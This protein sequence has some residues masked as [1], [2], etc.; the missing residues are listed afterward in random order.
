MIANLIRWAVN[1][2]LIVI[3]LTIALAAAGAYAFSQ[4][5]VEAYPDP[6]PA[7]VEVVAQYP[8]RSAEEVER[9]VTIPLEVGLSGMPGLK[10]V[11]SKSLFGLSFIS[12]QFEYG[13]SY[14]GARQEVINRI[15]STNLPSNV[16]PQISPRSPIGEILRYVVTGPKDDHG[17]NIYSLNDLRT[18]ESWTLERE[19]RRIV[20]IADV[21]SFGGTIKRYEIH[22]DPDRMKRYG[23]TLD[24]LQSAVAASNDNVSGDY[25]VQGESV[26]VVRGLGLIG[27]GRDPMQRILQMNSAEEAVNY[28]RNEE[29][30]R[31]REIRQIVL[32]STNNLPVRVGDIVEGGPLGPDEESSNRGVVV[33]YQTRLGKVGLSRPVKDKDGIEVVDK[34]D[35][36]EWVDEGDA[37]QGLAL[38]RKGAESLPALKL[39]EA[40]I[41]ELNGTPGRLPP[42]VKIETFYDRTDLINLTTETVEENL[43][44]GIVLVTVILLMFLSNVR[45]AII[46]AINLPLALL[47]AFGALYARGQS[48]NLL[49]IGAVDFGIIVDSTVIMVENIYRSLS[50]GKHTELPLKERI[51]LAAH[52][53]ERSLFFS[54]L[55]MVCAMLPLFTMRG[56]EGQLFRPMAETYAFAIGGALLL[57]LTL[58]PVLCLLL[59][60][61]LQ[62]SRDNFLVRFLKRGYLRNL[63][64]CLNHRALV[65]GGFAALLVGT[66]GALP[67]LGREFM[68]PLEEGHLWIRGFYPV[69]IS[70]DQNAEKSLIARQIM[71][72]YPEVEL[73]VSQM[74][75]PDSGVDP[76]SFYSCETLVP[77]KPFENWPATVK[78]TGWKSW[79]RD[80]R[81]RTKAELIDEMS[82]ELNEILPG[83][84]WTFTQTIRDTVLEVL[85]GVQGENSVKIIGADLDELEAIGQKVVN[86]IRDVP[87]IQ[88]VGLYRIK[89]QSNLELPIDRE[90]CALWNIKPA[91]VHAVIQSAIGGQA[92][93]QMIEG[94]KSFDITIRWPKHLREDETAILDIPVDVISHQ[95]TG[96]AKQGVGSTPVSGASESVA[97]T[98]FANPLPTLTGSKRSSVPSEIVTTPRERIRD[99]VTPQALDPDEPLDPQG[100]FIRPGASMIVRDQG[101]RVMSVKFGVRGRD[102]AGAVI[103]A[104]KKVAAVIPKGYRTVWSGEFQQM[105]DG[106]RRLMFIIPLALALIF[107]LLYLAFHSF[108]DAIVVLFNV[109]A[110]SLGGI[111]AL[112]LTGTSFSIA[113]AVGFTSIFGVAIMDGLLLVS[114][115]NHLR[116]EG[117]PLRE[118]IMTGAEQRIRPVMMT[119]L[120]AIFGLLPA[121]VSMKVGAQTQKPLA[122]VVVGSM[123]TTLLLT[124][125]LMPLLYSLY[126]GREPSKDAAKMVH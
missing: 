12:T 70:L 81:P 88:D 117:L 67:F 29:Q 96:G 110:L 106:E 22:P 73:A 42:G 66:V 84:N 1:N 4:V 50:A 31:L 100:R 118:A 62:P 82:A 44:L 20:G 2:A 89:G 38:L 68:P 97:S 57:A 75:R 43:V 101:N 27:R 34:N 39:L 94:E 91:D 36:R 80:K 49:S 51:V 25:L 111:W 16:S 112:M 64:H 114:S 85:S 78:E 63:E 72:R 47:F 48:A 71:R 90:K 41:A 24:Q 124:R 102:L 108:V 119:A 21:A 6:A 93:S 74:G 5:N 55:I 86:A 14:L 18:V 33:G 107:I 11:R 126:G 122:I 10:Y 28:L 46:I 104:Q 116:A 37:V 15:Q 26:A 60:K 3:L 58:A 77:L 23:I 79:F 19:F 8:G 113:A 105:Q 56:P 83:V 95:V 40:K 123:I 125:Y 98:G 87:G 7:V 30:R 120:T 17:N 109:L 65:L 52:E 59:F 92:V 115:F 69:S 61:H 53:V 45:S 54:T 32:A 13:V 9:L 99:L 103:E 121:A 76:T 35:Q